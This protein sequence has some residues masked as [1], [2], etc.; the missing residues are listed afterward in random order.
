[1]NL[2]QLFSA[3]R[4]GSSLAHASTWANTAAAVSALTGVLWAAV[5]LAGAFG[6]A[7]P[8]TPDQINTVAAGVVALVSVVSPLVHVAANPAAG[9]PPV[10]RPDG[11]D[12]AGQPGGRAPG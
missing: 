2:L 7:L 11:L 8:A 9:L 12:E 10:G 3:L 1:M 5:Q 4:Q 6:Y